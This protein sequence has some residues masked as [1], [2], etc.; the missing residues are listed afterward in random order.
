LPS[1][2]LSIKVLSNVHIKCRKYVVKFRFT[3]EEIKHYFMPTPH[4]IYSYVVQKDK[5]V[6]DFL[7]FYSLPSHIMKH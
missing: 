7:S 4:V 2:S 1:Q 6:T 3:E 5:D